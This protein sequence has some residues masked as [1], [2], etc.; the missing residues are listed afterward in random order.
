MAKRIVSKVVNSLISK[1]DLD[2]EIQRD[3]VVISLQDKGE[4][5]T[6]EKLDTIISKRAEILL[7]YVTAIT[8][9]FNSKYNHFSNEFC[10]F[11]RIM[12]FHLDDQP[13]LFYQLVGGWIFLRCLIPAI[14]SPENC[15][16]L[17][18]KSNSSISRTTRR[19][20]ILI[21]K[22]LQS[23]ANDSIF[24]E[25]EDYLSIFTYAKNTLRSTI[26]STIDKI[27]QGQI[28]YN[29]EMECDPKRISKIRGLSKKV[30]DLFSF[31][32]NHMEEQINTIHKTFD[33]KLSTDEILDEF[34]ELK[35]IIS[36][37]ND[38]NEEN[39]NS[40]WNRMIR[41]RDSHQN[42]METFV[43]MNQKIT[44]PRIEELS[45]LVQSQRSSSTSLTSSSDFSLASSETDDSTD[46]DLGSA[47]IKRM[48]K[49]KYKS[50]VV[51]IP[52]IMDM[53]ELTS[54]IGSKFGIKTSFILSYLAE[55]EQI[56]IDDF[57]QW[58]YF[59]QN[60]STKSNDVFL[61]H[62]FVKLLK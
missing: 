60:Y 35:S 22:I 15:K 18:R 46:S 56:N 51:N 21:G 54:K 43:N 25:K 48:M 47:E 2:L 28:V 44:S 13:N 42:S 6:E 62:I 53:K 3:K 11:V 24:G 31:H 36:G 61:Y 16:N 41:R 37:D 58:N 45:W 4:I 23:T 19:N 30:S 52:A 20:L 39:C 7:K 55:G 32:I 5:V 34:E 33:F 26:N 38:I 27:C 8:K 9:R 50:K 1:P 57:E 59:L 49:I 17:L 14:V 29:R 12:K 10:D 40:K